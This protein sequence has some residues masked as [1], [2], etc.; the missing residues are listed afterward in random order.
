MYSIFSIMTKEN[1]P[2]QCQTD[3]LASFIDAMKYHAPNLKDDLQ[4]VLNLFFETE[5]ANDVEV[6]TKALLCLY[7]VQEL[8]KIVFE[9]E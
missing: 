2:T 1:Q 7:T 5:Q 8:H 6:R 9:N 4:H 3:L